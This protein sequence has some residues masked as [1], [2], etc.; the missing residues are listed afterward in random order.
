MRYPIMASIIKHLLTKSSGLRLVAPRLN[1][2]TGRRSLQQGLANAAREHQT[3]SGGI[4]L[5]DTM[6]L[7]FQSR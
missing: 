5:R 6:R 7:G 1:E 2:A 3:Q 4:R